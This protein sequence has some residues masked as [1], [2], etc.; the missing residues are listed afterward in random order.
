[1]KCR[2]SASGLITHIWEAGRQR[3]NYFSLGQASTHLREEMEEEHISVADNA[4]IKDI[5][6]A[7]RTR[8]G[9]IASIH[10]L[11]R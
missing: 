9:Q 1:M 3:H 7:A 6:E 10:V 2:W 5:V 8:T 4:A 11:G